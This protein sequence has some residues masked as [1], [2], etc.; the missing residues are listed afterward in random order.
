M[1]KYRI[2]TEAEI[3]DLESKNC[4]SE[5]WQQVFVVEGF[6]TQNIRN[7]NFSGE[8]FLGKFDS[9][10]VLQGN[11][12]KQSGIYNATIHNCK[13]GNNV[14]INQVRSYLANYII[15]DNVLIDNVD[16]MVTENT[17]TFGNGTKVAVM[18]EAGGR[19]VPIFDRLTAQIAYIL[20]MYRDRTHTIDILNQLIDEYSASVSSNMGIVGRNSSIISCK[21]IKN[22]KIGEYAC[23][24]NIFRLQ[25]GSVNSCE[26]APTYIGLGVIAENF[27]VAPGSKITDG[28]LLIN[29]FVGEACA[30]GKQYSAENSLFFANCEGYHGEACSIFAGPFTVTHH[31]SSLLIAGQFS[32]MNAGSGSNQSNHLY[33]LGPVH[34]GILERGAKTASESYIM[35]PAKIGPF[36]VVMGRHTN[37]SDTSDIPFSYLIENDNES[38]LV[39][40]VNLKSIGT[41]RDAQKW[42]L[43]DKRTPANSSDCINFNLLS[44][45]TIHR[46]YKALD[47]LTNLQNTSGN[48][49]QWYAYKSTKIKNTSLNKGINF[50]KI[51]IIK[52]LGNSLISRIENAN[53]KS[54]ADL[55]NVLKPDTDT[56]LGVWIDLAGLIAPKSE[57]QNLLNEIDSKNLSMNDIID[58][59]KDIHNNYYTYEWT[60]ALNKLE[61]MLEKPY[62]EFTISDMINVILKWKESIIKLDYMLYEDAK[63]EF[64]SLSKTGFGIDGED[65]TCNMDFESVRGNFENNKFVK[66]V[67]NHIERKSELG[68]RVISKLQVIRV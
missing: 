32:F 45:F 38:V 12:V 57:I 20:A 46:M 47:V 21:V 7:V 22:V 44:P 53:I 6:S 19:E 29:C 5:N 34:Q 9:E 51:G 43:R 18:C 28:V 27:I 67:L 16:I 39:P 36:T 64:S 61:A 2:L 41:I 30:L 56:G 26:K 62:T 14:C 23:I 33:K 37:N 49:S 66:E 17:S 63:K 50:Y 4:R 8:V 65:D 31:K 3:V 11:V 24:D 25:N 54:N 55:V 35:W 40:G 68:D 15:E 48:T 60:W 52:F 13:I 10:F 42:P 59:F 1:N 58:R